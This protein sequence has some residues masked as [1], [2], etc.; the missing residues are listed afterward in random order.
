ME[1]EPEPIKYLPFPSFSTLI[2]SILTLTK[3]LKLDAKPFLV[4]R[5]WRMKRDEEIA[6]RDNLSAEKKEATQKA[7]REYLDS[8]YE[9]YNRDKDK[10]IEQ[11]RKQEA[12]Y[13][14]KKG[15][16]T[17]GGTSW[18]RITKLVDLSG[19]GANGGGPGSNKQKFRTMLLDLKKDLDA[20]GA[21]GV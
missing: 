6:R 19:K 1:Q 20:P 9:K 3:Q 5:S 21:K 10:A 18:D 13:L 14:E 15:D 16:T 8:F 11:F 17:S 7:A 12:E 4:S 2:I